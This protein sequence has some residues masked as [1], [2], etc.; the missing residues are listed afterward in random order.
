MLHP[1][2]PTHLTAASTVLKERVQVLLLA[3]VKDL[4]IPQLKE[5]LEAQTT[6]LWE[7]GGPY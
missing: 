1:P 4:Y 7:R 3:T 5:D 2:P 6:L